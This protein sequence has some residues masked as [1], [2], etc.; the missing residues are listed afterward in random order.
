MTIG[1]EHNNYCQAMCNFSKEEMICMNVI[2]IDF[3][4]ILSF[5]RHN[6]TCNYK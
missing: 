6:N 3:F 4:S 2:I 1:Q 5:V